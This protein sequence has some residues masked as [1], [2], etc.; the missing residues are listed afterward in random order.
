M[1]RR[2]EQACV[3]TLFFAAVQPEIRLLATTFSFIGLM[4]LTARI[5]SK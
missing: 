3:Y 4:N 2:C 1:A 5:S